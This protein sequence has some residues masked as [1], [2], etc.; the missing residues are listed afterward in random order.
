M[1][2]HL[3]TTWFTKYFKSTAESWCSENK[4]IPFKIL[5][6]TDNTPGHPRALMEMFTINVVLILANKNA[7]F[8]LQ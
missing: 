6:L 7:A 4:E 5:L 2:T 3:F 8:I 1:S